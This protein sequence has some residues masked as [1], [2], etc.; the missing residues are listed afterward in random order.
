MF[1]AHILCLSLSLS[2]YFSFPNPFFSHLLSLPFFLSHVDV[3]ENIVRLADLGGRCLS[4][5]FNFYFSFFSLILWLHNSHFL[6]FPIRE[7]S[8]HV[9]GCIGGRQYINT[10]VSF[11]AL[12]Y[13][14][15]ISMIFLRERLRWISIEICQRYILLSR[16]F[17]WC[18]PPVLLPHF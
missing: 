10:T 4:V 5:S 2:H 15:L 9:V 3:D 17:F 12:E 18:V 7:L 8:R 1:Q 13:L 16:I 11:H 6:T 14:L